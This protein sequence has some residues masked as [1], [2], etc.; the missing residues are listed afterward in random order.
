MYAFIYVGTERPQ[1]QDINNFVV[2]KCATYWK[3]LGRNLKISEDLLN[4]IEKDYPH[5]CES[6]CSKMLNEWLD[7]TPNA[8]WKLLHDA[9]DTTKNDLSE[10]PEAVDKLETVASKFEY[11]CNMADKIQKWGN[12]AGELPKVVEQLNQTVN[13]LSETA[14][15]RHITNLDKYT[16][17]FIY[18][19]SKYN[20]FYIK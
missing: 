15:K 4:I 7:L 10:V 3:Q 2:I 5:D 8:S 18:I 9:I 1:V 16:G 17:M 6:C 19:H 12:V 14:D 13:R 20:N 11:L